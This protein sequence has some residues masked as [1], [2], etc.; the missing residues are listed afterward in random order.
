MDAEAALLIANGLKLLGA[1]LAMTGA[2]GAGAGVG[3]AASGGVQENTPLVGLMLAP[4]GAPPSRLNV[5]ACPS[6]SVALAAKVSRFSSVTTPSAKTASAGGW[7]VA[8]PPMASRPAAL[9]ALCPSGLTT[10][11]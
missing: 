5:S 6:G 9:V 11:T 2:I 3:I 7:L 10:V 4:A 1:G 8:A